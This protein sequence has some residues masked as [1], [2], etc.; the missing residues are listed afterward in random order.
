MAALERQAQD[1]HGMSIPSLMIRA[2][3][4]TADVARRLLR[5]RGGRR[6]VVLVGKGNNG[7][8]GLVAARDLDGDAA[9]VALMV[10]P[11]ASLRGDPAAHLAA[12]RGRRARIEDSAHLDD[13]ALDGLLRDADLL[14]DAIFGTGFRGPAAGEPARVIEAAN[15]SGTPILAVDVPSGIDAATGGAAA[16]CVHAVATVTMGLPKRGLMQYPAAAHAGR[17]Y[18][19]DIGLPH[20]LVDAAPIPVALATGPWVNRTLPVRPADGQKGQFGRVALVAGARGFVGAAI[21]AA[22]GA[23]RAGAG[24]VTIGLPGSLAAVPAGSLPEAMTR[25]LPETPEGTVAARALEEIVEWAAAS[26]VLAIGPGLTMHAEVAALVRGLLP[27]LD[28]PLVAD[29]DALN[30]L[31]G[32]PERLGAVRGPVVITPHPGEMARLLGCEIA[33]VQRD[34]VETARSASARLGVVVVLKGARSVVASPDGRALVVPTG[35]GAMATGGMGDVLTGAT[36]AFLGAGMPAFEAAGCAVY[37]HG[38]AGDLAARSELGLLAHEV[39]DAIP[40]ALAQVRA[41][42]VDDGVTAVP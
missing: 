25:A 2:G 1:V 23:I 36:A 7:G 13:A 14:I 6:V 35:N 30:A 32:E 12:L 16:P 34:R 24:L 33:D 19:A 28:R 10:V 11:D 40:R 37:L 39:A 3:A 17:V 15:R 27:R 21:L 41:G 18:V 5:P 9:V 42:E 22:R 8:D 4:G 38:R 20:A 29:A 31:A 26:S